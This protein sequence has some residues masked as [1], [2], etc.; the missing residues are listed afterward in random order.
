M[1][2]KQITLALVALTMGLAM[3]TQASADC[4]KRITLSA[5]AAGASIG[6]SGTAEVRAVGTAQRF[7]VS[8][9]ADVANGTTFNVFANGQPAGTITIVAFAGELDINNNNG[10][11]L[12]AGVS[13]VCS[14]PKLVE[15][16]DG[17]G[18][19]ILSGSF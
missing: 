3:V 12:P 2:R 15:V 1:I 19:V 10:N 16:K 13:P 6:A 4:R 9:D 5:S 11:V 17:S 7:K 18:T 8:I 14:S